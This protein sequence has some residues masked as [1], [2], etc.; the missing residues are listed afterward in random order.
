MNDKLTMLTNNL[1]FEITVLLVIL[2]LFVA[3]V[4]SSL[5]YL[6]TRAETPQPYCT[7]YSSSTGECIEYQPII[8]GKNND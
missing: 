1:K 4:S 8:K 7:K 5:T 3:M 6:M 2:I